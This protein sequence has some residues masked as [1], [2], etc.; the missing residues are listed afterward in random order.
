MF[1]HAFWI[2]WVWW[3][4][5][6]VG[7]SYAAWSMR[8]AYV[9]H[10]WT[11]DPKN[12]ATPDARFFTRI[13]FSGSKVFLAKQLISLTAGTFAILNAPPPPD[14]RYVPQSIYGVSALALLSL[15]MMVTQIRN[16]YWRLQMT[17]GEFRENFEARTTLQTADSP[18]GTGS[19]PHSGRF[20]LH[21]GSRDDENAS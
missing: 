19:E 10:K 3:G 11:E 15:L 2:E 5:A 16:A 8:R 13:V 4:A 21:P 7:S 20:P 14:Y 1:V 12:K 6:V 18:D 9:D 17:S